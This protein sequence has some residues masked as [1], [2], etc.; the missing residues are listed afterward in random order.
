MKGE[1]F[2]CLKFFA[3]TK[4]MHFFRFVIKILLLLMGVIV[5]NAKKKC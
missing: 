3:E 5:I 4:Y 1:K 2:H